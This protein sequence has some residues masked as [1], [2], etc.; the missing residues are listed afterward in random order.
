M[1][2][3]S[4]MNR[5]LQ[6]PLRRAA[7]IV[8]AGLALFVCLAP[9]QTG[10]TTVKNFSVPEYYDPPHE[11]QIKSLLQGAEAEPESGGLV[12]I[13]ELRLQTFHLNGEFDMLVQAPGCVFDS[14]GRTASSPGR[15]QVR[16]ADGSFYLEGEGF[17]WQQT[18]V[19]L[20]ISNQVRTVLQTE[21]KKKEP[22]P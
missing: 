22:K 19:N 8:P 20:I 16:T 4:E 18:N 13:R 21:P 7:R 14:V 2:A 9:G 10:T 12:R 5:P 1:P 17:L 11:T 15:L 3:E 6:R